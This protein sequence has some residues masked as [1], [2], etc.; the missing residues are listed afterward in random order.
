[1]VHVASSP[2]FSG[3]MSKAL[4][5][6]PEIFL[7]FSCNIHNV[8][9]KH[10][11]GGEFTIVF[12]LCSELYYLWPTAGLTL[13]FLIPAEWNMVH[14][15]KNRHAKEDTKSVLF[16]KQKLGAKLR[17]I[18]HRSLVPQICCCFCECVCERNVVR[19]YWS[20]VSALGMCLNLLLVGL[21][22]YL[23]PL[24]HSD[25]TY[26]VGLPWTKDRPVAETST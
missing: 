12:C 8:V 10:R 22:G 2:I 25:T 17:S 4:S 9:P 14:N 6:M 7:R 13:Y 11:G 20:W 18:V 3:R 21:E 24:S 26:S 16:G 23:C 15:Q 5:R 19:S 1:M